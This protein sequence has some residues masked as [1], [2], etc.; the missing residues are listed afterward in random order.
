MADERELHRR[1]ADEFG[2][3]V[4]SVADDQWGL[5][6]P[7]TEWDVR[8]L[9]NH[10]VSENRWVPELVAGKRVEDVGDRFDGDLLGDDPKAA[11][12]D[13]IAGASAAFAQEGALDR[14]VH[15]SFADVP[16]SEYLAQLTSDLAV[17]AWDLA[18]AIGHD[19]T[20]GPELVSFMWELW[21]PRRDMVRGS[22]VFGDEVGVPE[23]A[24]LQTRLLGY[25]GR[26]RDWRA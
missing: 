17:H 11:W 21:S 1:A 4:E 8:A 23:D 15:L 14:T 5:P 24:D 16:G 13:S 10:L 26:R 6:T 12:R 25:L 9:V 20:I 19:D 22:G 7:C 3:R 2:R 18:K